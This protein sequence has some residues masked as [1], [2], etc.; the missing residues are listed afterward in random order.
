MFILIMVDNQLVDLAREGDP[1]AF[2]DLYDQSKDS[3]YRF[4]FYKLGS[5]EDAEDA[6][7]DCV[8][9]AWR[10]IGNL[11]SSEAFSTWIFRILTG[12][13]NRRIKTLIKDRDKVE[14]VVQ[15]QITDAAV[16][17]SAKPGVKYADRGDDQDEIASLTDNIDLSEALGQLSDQEREVVLLSVVAG[18]TSAE[19]GDMTGLTAGGVRS[20][21]SRSLSKM[22]EFMEESA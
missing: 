12:C 21:L 2:C 16:E 13:C 18:F 19:V 14:A 6:V 7:Q 10:Q 4:A 9:D 1:K 22:R 15:M 17:T 3:L 11:R 8:M 20:K 5:H